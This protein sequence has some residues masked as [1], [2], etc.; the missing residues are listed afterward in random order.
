LTALADSSFLST[1]FCRCRH[2]RIYIIV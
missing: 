1:E 2:V